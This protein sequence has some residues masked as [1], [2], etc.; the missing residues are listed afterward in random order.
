MCLLDDSTENVLI[1]STFQSGGNIQMAISLSFFFFSMCLALLESLE[2]KLSESVSKCLQ[3]HLLLVL[4]WSVTVYPVWDPVST[5]ISSGLPTR[6]F[7]VNAQSPHLVSVWTG[8]Q[9]YSTRTSYLITRT[10]SAPAQ[11][12]LLKATTLKKKFAQLL[13]N[14]KLSVSHI[15]FF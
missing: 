11:P 8:L 5:L 4:S 12:P 9:Q 3:G 6:L 13:T 2:Y 10:T 7:L 14:D 15:I 1:N